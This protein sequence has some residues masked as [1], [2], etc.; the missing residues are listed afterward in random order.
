MPTLLVDFFMRIMY[1]PRSVL[2]CDLTMELID[3]TCDGPPLYKMTIYDID[4]ITGEPSPHYY[5][6]EKMINPASPG[7]IVARGTRVWSAREMNGARRRC[8][9]KDYWIDHDRTQK[10]ASWPG[11]R[12]RFLRKIRITLR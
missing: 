5:I 2:G 11:S 1:A 8:V 12:I 4:T 3:S 7:G 9:I 10:E 6:T